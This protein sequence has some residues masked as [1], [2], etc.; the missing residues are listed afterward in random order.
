MTEAEIKEFAAGLPGV[1]VETAS[2]ASGA[3]EAAWGDSF[4]YFDG[5]GASPAGAAVSVR[6]DRDP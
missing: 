5:A 3:P 1:S 2:A 6:D 4:I